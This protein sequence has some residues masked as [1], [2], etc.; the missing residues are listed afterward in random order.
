M[1]FSRLTRA[2]NRAD[3]KLYRQVAARVR[4][5]IA[6]GRL[7]LGAQLPTEAVLARGFGVSLI[8]VRHALRELEAEGLIEKRP[9][10]PAVVVS[11][12]PRGPAA[13]R[14]NSLDDIAAATEGASLEIS[15]WGSARSAAAEQLFG[16]AAGATVPCLRGRVM[17]DGRAM[18]DVT[19]FFPPAIG[20]RLTRR[21]FD[22]VVVFR[23]V[24]RHLGLRLSGVRVTVRAALADAALARRLEVEAGA[25]VLVSEIVYLDEAG[26]PAEFTVARHRGDAYSLSYAFSAG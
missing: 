1:P 7:G 6:E 11:T 3:G 5:A 18:S 12:E 14:M 24:Q 20:A 4:A 8:T 10:K 26:Q 23:S 25:A 19:I 13:R 17:R 16:L 21:D 2:L 22:D 15:D 9:A